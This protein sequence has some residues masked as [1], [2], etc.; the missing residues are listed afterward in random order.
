MASTRITNDPGRI[1]VKLQQST[2]QGNWVIDVPGNGSKPCFISDPHIRIQKFGAN[3]QTNTIDLESELK[4]INRRLSNGVNTKSIS[5][6]TCSH[7][8][9]DQSR[10][11]DPAWTLREISSVP[12]NFLFLNPQENCAFAF[13]NNLSTR[14]LE[15]DYFRR[16]F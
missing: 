12:Q 16:S 15:K 5:Y 9:T 7:L 8:T 2:D 3:R 11:S 6:P 13:E 4:G 10:T 14:I 1:M